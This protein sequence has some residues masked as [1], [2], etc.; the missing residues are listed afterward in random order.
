MK[1]Y[2]DDQSRH[3]GLMEILKK[4][5]VSGLADALHDLD[6]ETLRKIFKMPPPLTANDLQ[7]DKG[8]LA[9][10]QPP[11]IE[12]DDLRRDRREPADRHSQ[13]NEDQRNDEKV[14]ALKL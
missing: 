7:H 12:N 11:S 1:V 10:H 9:G 8:E 2:D 14:S 3:S 13:T 5:D 4:S 6:D